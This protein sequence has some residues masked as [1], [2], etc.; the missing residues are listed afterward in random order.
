MRARRWFG[1]EGREGSKAPIRDWG[2]GEDDGRG[3]MGG[4]A[5]RQAIALQIR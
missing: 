4:L 1:L 5:V 3:Q 2:L